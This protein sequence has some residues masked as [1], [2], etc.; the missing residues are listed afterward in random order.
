MRRGGDEKKTHWSD[1][2]QVIA[3]SQLPLIFPMFAT[4]LRRLA[5]TLTLSLAVFGGT[6]VLSNG[7]PATEP[8]PYFLRC[9]PP[10]TCSD[11]CVEDPNEV[12]SYSAICCSRQ[13]YTGGE[14]QDEYEDEFI[15]YGYES[16]GG[17]GG[18]DLP[19]PQ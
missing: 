17:G 8:A 11:N 16:S 7:R 3:L 4:R 18:D 13:Y 9:E 12:C 10:G 14:C 2:K 1:P 6:V 15:C 19:R 5:F